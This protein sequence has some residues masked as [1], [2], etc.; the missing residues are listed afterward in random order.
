MKLFLFLQLNFIRQKKLT[1][2]RQKN[3]IKNICYMSETRTPN[4]SSDNFWFSASKYVATSIKKQQTDPLSEFLSPIDESPEFYDPYS[5]L[6]LFLSQKIKQE[7]QH[8]GSSKKWSL[9][10]QEELISKIA[11][12]FQKK[13][14][15]YRLRVSAL[16][17]SWE[18]IVYYSQQI[19]NQKEAINED[20]KLNIH[21]FIKENLKNYT[22]LKNPMHLQPYH[23]AHQLAAKMSECIAVIDGVR[24]PL[25]HLTKVIWAVQRHLL[26]GEE[27]ESYQCPYD[28][29]DKIDK[30]IVKL[31]LEISAKDPQITHASLEHKVKEALQSLQEL[32]SFASHEQMVCNV[33]AL[34][35]EKLYPASP[36]LMNE[37]KNALDHF[38]R[39]HSSLFKTAE[40]HAHLPELVR[41]ISALY[42][43]ASGLPKNL[44]REEIES[45]VFAMYPMSKINRPDLPQS[46]YAF[47][48]AELVL[49][50]N[51]AFCH[52]PVFVA[53]C[54]DK[55]Y[56]EVILL[57]T[58]HGDLLAIA[59]WKT[60]SET[61]GLL[62][63]LPYRIGQ[64]IE[65]EIAGI[66]IEN[67]THSFATL[68]YETVQFFIRTKELVQLKKWDEIEK[69]IHIWAVQGDMLCRWIQLDPSSTLLRLICQKWNEL[70]STLPHHLFVSGICQE[71]LKSYPELAP[72]AGQL[73]MRVWILYKY[74]WYSVFGEKEES[75]FDRFLKWHS[76]SLLFSGAMR[77]HNYLLCQLEEITRNALPLMPFDKQQADTVLLSS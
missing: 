22:T 20:G 19:Q 72:Y 11:P 21:F 57:P 36:L 46:L 9:K 55:A 4:P 73:A 28:C 38:I 33:S 53:E 62:E 42:M 61:E 47:I 35:A 74:A 16:K 30:L 13:F 58:V 51:E 49:M 69:K 7:L 65:D 76:C 15:R 67:P 68:V 5:D 56:R 31:I 1:Y 32:P 52:S 39:R 50:R 27:P 18:K 29:S 24:P 48:S 40:P 25:D 77:D 64:R 2:V 54:I 71:Y 6:N 43:L 70:S 3:T 37:Q 59:V 17:K 60:L 14:P 12:E 41:R 66:L 44:S 23:Y 10:I 45:A 75:S 34:L 63:K 8:C 26:S